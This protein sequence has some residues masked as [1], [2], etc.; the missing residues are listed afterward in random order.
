MQYVHFKKN[1]YKFGVVNILELNNSY[2]CKSCVIRLKQINKPS[3]IRDTPEFKQLQALLQSEVDILIK[4][5]LNNQTAMSNFQLNVKSI[6]D[7]HYII[8]YSYEISNNV[9]V[10]IFVKRVPLYGDLLIKLSTKG[11][12]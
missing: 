12:R 9:L 3:G 7:K 6:L 10:G 2:I 8:D 1:L 5:G 11:N 4:R